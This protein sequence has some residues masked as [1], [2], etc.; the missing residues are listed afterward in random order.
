MSLISVSR[1]F[2]RAAKNGNPVDEFLIGFIATSANHI[3]EELSDD[4]AKKVFWLNL[5][6][7]FVLIEFRAKRK[8]N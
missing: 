3:I 7:A 8:L 1:D 5:Y 6:N 2:L 4:N